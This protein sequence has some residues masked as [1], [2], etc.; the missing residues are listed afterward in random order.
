MSKTLAK[1][2]PAKGLAADLPAVAVARDFWTSLQNIA[3]RPFAERAAGYAAVYATPQVEVRSLLNVSIGGTNYWLYNGK[4]R[5]YAV[6]GVTHTD[7]TI[8][9]TTFTNDTRF[10]SWSVGVFNGLAFHNH[11]LDPPS[12]WD[13]NPANNFVALPGWPGGVLCGTLRAFGNF[14]IAMN[15]TSY[16]DQVR[17]S[18]AA[19]AGAMPSTWT[20]A[21]TNEAGS[22]EL[23]DTPGGLIDGAPLGN[24][25]VIYKARSAYLLEYRGDNLVFNSR[26]LPIGR[27]LLA[28]NCI[29]EYRG[30]HFIV[31]ADGDFGLTDGTQFESV[32][33]NRT[34]RFVFSQLDQANFG[35][36]FVGALKRQSEIWV[37]FPSS[38]NTLCDLAAVWNTKDN[39]WSVRDVPLVS[40][41][42]P[43]VVSD[44]ATTDTWDSDAG[45][46]DGDASIWNEQS[47]LAAEEQLVLG[48]PNDAAPTSS[49]LLKM[50]SGLTA[51]GAAFDARAS[52]YGMDLGDATRVK[53]VRA[54][55]PHV[56][57]DAG[58]QMLVR[59]GGQMEA[60]GPTTWSTETTYTVGSGARVPLF[61]LGRFISVEF[62]STASAAWRLPAFDLE[63]EWRGYH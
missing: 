23:S 40:C 35:T 8:G 30:Q 24:G 43:G 26:L 57:A 27:G 11:D 41:A 14:L 6:Q 49:L 22:R 54:V 15:M 4:Q 33:D 10:N 36:V 21:A 39:T 5:S 58:T 56:I 38:G 12:Y 51:N 1:F 19:A 17:W 52:K 45:T 62:R 9:G 46:W 2:T 37:C 34:R 20:A 55:Y 50:D 29:A 42:A 7:V 60:N 3:C 18:A 25:F 13:G 32:A 63:Y 44:T 59:V 16:P 31:T 28:R 53:M 61:A 48:K 47:Q